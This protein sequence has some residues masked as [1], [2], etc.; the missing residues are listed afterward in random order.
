MSTIPEAT[1][2]LTPV[3]QWTFEH[4]R[5]D[6]PME[7][8]IEIEESKGPV[9]AMTTPRQSSRAPAVADTV[10]TRLLLLRNRLLL[11]R[12]RRSR[13]LCLGLLQ[14]LSCL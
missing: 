8:E 9:L 5:P 3:V 2:G 13:P 4:Y 7:S 10:T 6:S 12:Q 11:A 14:L 1:T